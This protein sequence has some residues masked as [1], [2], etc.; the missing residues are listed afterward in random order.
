MTDAATAIKTAEQKAKRQ[1]IVDRL[2]GWID[3]A[4]TV[5]IVAEQPG[6]ERESCSRL[7]RMIPTGELT[8]TLKL[9]GIKGIQTWL[10]DGGN[11]HEESDWRIA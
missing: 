11:R 3:T 5:D 4:E 8:I 9:T 6:M 1:A 10:I 7:A 2:M